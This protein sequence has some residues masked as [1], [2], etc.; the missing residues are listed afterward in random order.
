MQTA[1]LTFQM[2]CL[3]HLEANR[4]YEKDRFAETKKQKEEIN[5]DRREKEGINCD[6][7][8]PNVYLEVN[9]TFHWFLSA[10]LSILN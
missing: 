4:L 1:A 6:T 5:E 9:L 8:T 2:K 7:A 3:K 10:L